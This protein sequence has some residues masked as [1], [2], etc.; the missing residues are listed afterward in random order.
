MGA[1]MAFTG[2]R[3]GWLRAV[4]T[5]VGVGV[6]VAM[7]LL[8]AAVPGALDA[9]QARGDARDDL[10]MGEKIPAAANTLLI[11]QTD[12]EFRGQPVRGRVLRPEGPAAPVPPGVAAL[13]RAGEVLVSPALRDLLGSADGALFAPRLGGATV[14]G[15]IADEG[16]A[17]PARAGLLPG[18]RHPRPPT[19]ATRLDAFGGGLPGEA[20][21][22]GAGGAGRRHLRGPA[23]AHRGLPRR[24]GA[25]RR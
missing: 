16:L 21:R 24:G 5:A 1:R 15:I 18:Q 10:R 20:S 17:G 13:P 14:T 12:T 8:A 19:S 3:D 22:P 2:G 23:A 6:G 7:L 11:R 9:R 25:V 4:L